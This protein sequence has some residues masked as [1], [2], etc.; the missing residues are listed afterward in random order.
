MM[1]NEFLQLIN[2]PVLN[3]DN[4]IRYSLLYQL[5]GESLADHISDVSVLSYLLTLRLNSY[6][7]N[8]DVGLV[9]EN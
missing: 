1:N 3:T 4:A 7:E 8:L 5:K 6:G 2:M 9:L